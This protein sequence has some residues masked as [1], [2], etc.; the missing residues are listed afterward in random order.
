MTIYLFHK[1]QNTV[2]AW[3]YKEVDKVEILTIVWDEIQ[4]HF[5]KKKP[6]IHDFDI[7]EFYLL[8]SFKTFFVEELKEN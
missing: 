7:S 3:N 6:R 2:E 4:E 5:N 8:L 1:L